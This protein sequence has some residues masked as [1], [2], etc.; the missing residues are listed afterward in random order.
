MTPEAVS[1]WSVAVAD[2]AIA[3][4]VV[5]LA[6]AFSIWV[7]R[8]LTGAREVDPMAL[9]RKWESEAAAWDAGYDQAEKDFE[10]GGFWERGVR[11]NPHDSEAD[12]G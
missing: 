6:V 1:I 2:I 9:W 4:A 7:L 12:R 5:L 3:G 8:K 10:A 11:K